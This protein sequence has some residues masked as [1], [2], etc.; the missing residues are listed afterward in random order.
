MIDFNA[1]ATLLVIVFIVVMQVPQMSSSFAMHHA[2]VLALVLSF[3]LAR[4][5]D[6]PHGGEVLQPVCPYGG[7]PVCCVVFGFS[8]LWNVSS[9][10][11]RAVWESRRVRKR[12]Q[13][14]FETLA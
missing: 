2:V 3:S 1:C 12:S 9:L 4:A 13:A 8:D 10:T 6:R 5:T 14:S 11:S 7:Q